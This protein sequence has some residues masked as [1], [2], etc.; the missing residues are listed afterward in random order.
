MKITPLNPLHLKWLCGM[1]LLAAGTIGLV[2]PSLAQVAVVDVSPAPRTKPFD[3]DAAYGYQANTDLKKANGD[4]HRNAFRIGL[5]AEIA[6]SDS[7]KVDNILFYTNN[8]YTFSGNS[9]FQWQDIHQF[10]YAPLFKY[11]AS[12][13]WT[14]LGAPVV[15]WFGE[16]GAKAGDSVTGGGLVGFNYRSSPD[17]SVGLL[18]GVLS[19]IEDDAKLLPIPIVRWKFAKQWTARLGL[20]RLGPDVGLGGE[21]AFKLNKAVELAG[22][23]QYQRRRFRLDKNDR[24]GEETQA[25]LYGKFTWWMFPEA[26]LE[27]FASLVTNGT[28]RLENKNGNKITDKDYDS[29][30][31]FGGKLHFIF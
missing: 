19:Q 26:N 24:V 28:L 21:L 9:A 17:F 16:G 7:L 6:F 14:I 11:Q 4:F 30:A 8:N 20:N 23:I 12:E 29:T 2:G 25:P 13:R 1:F 10:V 22:G 31:F 15:Q 27:F 5:N 18:I 3:V